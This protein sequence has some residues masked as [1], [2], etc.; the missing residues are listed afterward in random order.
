MHFPFPFKINMA[1]FINIKNDD[2]SVEKSNKNVYITYILYI[3]YYIYTVHY[4]LHE[5]KSH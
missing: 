4:I 2:S 1:Y 3:I 5:F